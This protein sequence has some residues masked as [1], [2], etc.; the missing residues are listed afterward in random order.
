MLLGNSKH[1]KCVDI[2]T[3]LLQQLELRIL[4]LPN[5][6]DNVEQQELFFIVTSN[7]NGTATQEDNSAVSNKIKHAF[8]INSSDNTPWY[9]PQIGQTYVHTKTHDFYRGFTHN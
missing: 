9:L 4:T 8:T 5:A 6:G 3:Q 7:A 2:T 1:N